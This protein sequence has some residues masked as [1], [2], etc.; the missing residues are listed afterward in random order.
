MIV[1]YKHDEDFRFLVDAKLTEWMNSLYLRDN[2]KPIIGEDDYFMKKT[3]YI[4]LKRVLMSS[5]V[6]DKQD[7]QANWDILK[8]ILTEN[9]LS[10]A[11]LSR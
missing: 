5:T 6:P 1:K 7:L 8:D 10:L 4:I 11:D 9:S 2:A 3:A